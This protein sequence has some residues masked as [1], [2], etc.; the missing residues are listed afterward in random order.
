MRP[1]T[2]LRT[3]LHCL[4]G[5]ACAMLPATAAA[6]ETAAP[7]VILDTASYWRCHFTW[8]TVQL[9]RKSGELEFVSAE[10]PDPGR[11]R[12]EKAEVIVR[13]PLPEGNWTASDFDDSRWARA[14]GPLFTRGTRR[15]ALICARGK[16]TVED[17]ARAGALKLHLAYRGG[18]VVY[19]NGR[20]VARAHLPKE[21]AD[22]ETPAEDYP[23]EA[24]LAPD[25][26]LLRVGFRE[27]QRYPDRFA[28]RRRRLEAE[29][30]ASMLR[31]GVNVLAVEL[32]RAP[33]CEVFY[34]SRFRDSRNYFLWDMVGLEEVRLTGRT[35]GSVVP[36]VDRP[37][38]L[39][40][41]NHPVF[42][43]VHNTDH[44]DPAEGLRPIEIVAARN[45]A[46]SGQ[47]VVGSRAA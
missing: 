42:V 6:D 1:S 45:G 41:W 7:C 28:L 17:P 2:G 43:S 24:Y 46:F 19:V 36:N 13:S 22:L 15:I 47:V 37:E 34:T 29:V 8:K 30:P 38:G 3:V 25:G 9:R 32:H 18:A 20:E 12:V 23:E 26:Y 33:V 16:F 31:K 40:V 11:A 4:A 21:N 39:E 35:G 27:P 44:G 10:W 14:R 5:A